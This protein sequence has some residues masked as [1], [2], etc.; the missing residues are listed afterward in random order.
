MTPLS[1][2]V[3]VSRR[4]RRS[5]RIDT[6]LSDPG[7][8]DGFIC[9]E[10]SASILRTMALHIKKSGQAA[11]TWTGPYGVGKS[12]LVVALS[13]VLNAQTEVRSKASRI[14][15][16]ATTQAIWEAMPP[17]DKGWRVL[18]VVG[19]RDHPAQVVGEAIER[20]RLVRRRRTEPWTDESALDALAAAAMRQARKRGG[21]MLFI[22]EMGKFL[23]GAAYYGTDIYFFQQLAEIAS[24]S[25]GR[26]IVVGILHQ[27]FEEYAYRLSRDMRDEW[28]KV[29]GRF[30][31]L[32]INVDP[33][34]QIGLLGRAIE[35][36]G[37][38]EIPDHL[39]V[40]TANLLHRGL[41]PRMLEECWPLHPITACLLGPI[42]RRRFG[43]NQRSL[44]SF[45]SST[46]PSG[47]Q[48]FLR[49][50]TEGDLYAP[51]MVWDYL[52][53]NLEPSIVASPDGHRWAMAVD[54]LERCR[55]TGGSDVAVR[56]LKVIALVDLFKERSGLSAS[57]ELLKLS[58]FFLE[59][60]IRRA[61][62]RLEKA[63][64][65][66]FR[67][68]SNSYSIFEGSDFDI[69]HA[70]DIA[71]DSIEE[72]DFSR[73]SD[74]AGLQPVVAKRHYHKT[75][76]IR[77]FDMFIAPLR[78]IEDVV[79]NYTPENGSVG[80][81]ILTL[82]SHG[83]SPQTV[84]RMTVRLSRQQL[85]GVIVG[86]PQWTTGTIDSLVR[87]L[88]ALEQ[89][90][91]NSPELRGDRVARMEVEARI[92]DIQGRIESD[93]AMAL[94][95]AKWQGQGIAPKRLD[96]AELNSLASDIAD[97]SFDKSPQLRNELLNRLKPSSNAVAA[98]NALLRRMVLHEGQERLGIKGFPA[99]GGLFV[100]LLEST[101][102]YRH[103]MEGWR[104][105]APTDENDPCKLLPAWEEATK[106][107]ESQSHRS[108]PV[109]E[110][111]RIWGKA[112]FGIKEGLMPIL[113]VAFALSKRDSLAFYREGVF[114][115]RLTD[116]DTDYLTSDPADIQ[117]RWMDLSDVSRGLLSEMAAVVRQLDPRNALPDLE[118]ID[119]ARGLVAI[120][121]ALP[122]W[123][124]RTQQLSTNAK[125]VRQLFKQAKD[126]NRLIFDDIPQAFGD[127]HDKNEEEAVAEITQRVRDGLIELQQAYP[128]M[129]RR[130]R[131]TLLTELGVPNSSTESLSEL[132]ARAET[133]KQLSGDH[134]L[135]A[136]VLRISQFGGTDDDM[137][138]IAS[139]AANKPP[140]L[141]TDSEIDRARIELADMAR[142]FVR[143]EAYAH[144]KGRQ[145]RRH[146]IA[147]VVG[148][149]G[150]PIH[151][152]FE[153]TDQEQEKVDKLI[154]RV[155]NVL[156][157][158]G[159][160]EQNIIL[161]ALARV[162]AEY[163]EARTDQEIETTGE[164]AS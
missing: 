20:A 35:V 143:H 1:E 8:L 47:F 40:E 160:G 29:Q 15:G 149:D 90:R 138:S 16:S 117:F 48:D 65:I 107:L 43:Q 146:A 164:A 135:E 86:V 118:P 63:S 54:A 122:L 72:I 57:L 24:R 6:D 126:P 94:G 113:A 130:L 161:A 150:R 56:L 53:V 96:Q 106:V 10:S 120:Y 77:W 93:L 119:V 125:R 88:L 134:R 109:D 23:E 34:E 91:D 147:V 69:E 139:M 27:A 132:R 99:E 163:L 98:Q 85:H 112:P 153:V 52:R 105:V 45:L 70:V 75:G 19:R 110:I 97:S 44:F 78:D 41:P 131:E 108:V 124:E 37:D 127:Q 31:D 46:E 137:E 26:L 144:V 82:P 80:A 25:D 12:S 22:D 79:A 141:W 92:A 9:P 39:A 14:L 116:L 100:S 103:T 55:A 60:E 2:R 87:E 136:F 32:A 11:F 33:E 145:D 68:F 162:S 64:I 13:A 76:A 154:S 155:R 3:H 67:K 101:W 121:D 62:A 81:F 42:S 104:F 102:L 158:S 4:F 21:L 59:D 49:A 129:L 111:Y 36:S 152:A 95:G 115:V 114:Q 30:V 123:S 17:K 156:S 83:D 128:S 140:R 157:E 71:Y 66:I 159:E 51:D 74:L 50:A 73:L 5:I 61:L 7:A 18:P 84:E 151:D 38:Y 58:T 89:V 142:S 133:I 148:L 28:S